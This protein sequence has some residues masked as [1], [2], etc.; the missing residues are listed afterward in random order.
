MRLLQLVKYTK[1]CGT[2]EIMEEQNPTQISQP[3]ES[4]ETPKIQKEEAL[5]SWTA[6]SRPFK[7]RNREF[8]TTVAALAFLIGLIFFFLEGA[9]TVAVVIAIVFLVYVLS[10][11]QPE[12]VSCVVTN[13]GINFAGK[14]YP[15]SQLVRFWFTTRF[16][17]NLLVFQT[18][19]IPGRVEMVVLETDKEKIKEVLEDYLVYE[20]VAPS[21]LDKAASWFSKRIPLEG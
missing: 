21:F 17:H 5:F 20:E 18:V 16:G 1:N 8:F 14:K 13:K 11:V 15:W 10:T 6:P 19:N 4:T 2:M 9:L 3:T 7:K 12:D